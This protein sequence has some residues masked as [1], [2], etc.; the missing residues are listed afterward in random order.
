M[1]SS[2]LKLKTYT[3]QKYK[4]IDIFI[5]KRFFYVFTLV[6]LISYN[7]DTEQFTCMC[8]LIITKHQILLYKMYKKNYTLKIFNLTS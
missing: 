4:I 2:N 7:F 5:D 6:V 8:K 1:K 3:F